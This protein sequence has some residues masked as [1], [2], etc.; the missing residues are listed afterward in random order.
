MDSGG[1][2]GSSGH[3]RG[4]VLRTEVRS[5]RQNPTP[6]ANLCLSLM[7]HVL[8]T[9]N[10]T[11][12]VGGHTCV[13]GTGWGGGG[14][15][16]TGGHPSST[17]EKFYRKQTKKETEHLRPYEDVPGAFATH[18]PTSSAHRSGW[19]FLNSCFRDSARH[20]VLHDYF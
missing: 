15:P 1:I 2:A 20:Q 3:L 6:R 14:G 16:G 13:V 19:S 4:N 11:V 8:W 17:A 5:R 7:F 18:A 9:R 10:L 12:P